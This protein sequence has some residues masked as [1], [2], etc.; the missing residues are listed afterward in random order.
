MTHERRNTVIPSAAAA[1][2][3]LLV[4]TG[5]TS[6]PTTQRRIARLAAPVLS[7]DADANW[8][9]C[10][11]GLIAAGPDSVDWLMRRPC[12]Q[13]P[14]PPD[15]LHV[16][17]H[18]SLVALLAPPAQ[19]PALTTTALQVRHGLVY[20]ELR[21][22]GR[23]LGE[24][25]W[26]GLPPVE[27]PALLVRGFEPQRADQSDLER[28]RR[29]LLEWWR[30]RRSDPATLIRRQPYRPRTQKLWRLLAWYPADRWSPVGPA[31]ELC[32]ARPELSLTLP[33]VRRD[34]NLVRSACIWLGSRAEAPVQR[35]LID[36]VGS[37]LPV[38]RHN[39]LFALGYSPDPG[40][41][42]LLERWHR[43][44]PSASDP[45]L[46]VRAEKAG[47]VVAGARLPAG[48]RPK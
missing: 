39:A 6:V 13:R 46:W 16:L 7:L 18:T 38:L 40:I 44:R 19:R 42:A 11:N 48:D 5:C 25:V 21:V 9:A 24:A 43:R 1:V 14:A 31:G 10:V 32:D 28:D 36:L 2:V 34:Y 23:V 4:S 8:T 33:L 26:S 17:M 20:F 41:R 15:D 37:D 27:W 30:Q 22:R 47:R 35:R 12:M 3:L 45:G 29:T